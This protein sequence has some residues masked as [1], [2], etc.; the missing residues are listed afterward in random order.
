MPKP[1]LFR[2]NSN[3]PKKSVYQGS[4]KNKEFNDKIK[5]LLPEI[6]KH[7]VLM[8]TNFEKVKSLFE[9]KEKSLKCVPETVEKF[10]KDLKIQ[11][12]LDQNWLKLI[13]GLKTDSVSK[14]MNISV[15]VIE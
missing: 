15:Q 2:G 14:I 13:D 9:M 3:S 5:N 4:I 7:L 10:E 12:N 6:S 11:A 8:D 1:S